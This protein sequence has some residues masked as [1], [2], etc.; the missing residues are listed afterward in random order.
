MNVKQIY[1]EPFEDHCQLSN[2]PLFVIFTF[3]TDLECSPSA[4]EYV[5]PQN[6]PIQSHIF[7]ENDDLTSINNT[8][9][10][11][12][13]LMVD[14][15]GAKIPLLSP[16]TSY[17]YIYLRLGLITRDSRVPI[18]L[19]L[20]KVMLFP[21]SRPLS[22][23]LYLTVNMLNGS[24]TVTGSWYPTNTEKLDFIHEESDE[25][26]S[27]S[28]KSTEDSLNS[29]ENH[30]ITFYTPPSDTRILTEKTPLR[31][32]FNSYQTVN[33]PVDPP[34]IEV[35]CWIHFKIL[36]QET[37][38]YLFNKIQELCSSYHVSASEKSI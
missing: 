8:H 2:Q 17:K 11:Y 21:D 15:S 27:I 22:E 10:Q 20:R 34:K 13:I 6:D 1:V 28:L 23:S 38:Q 36:A 16:L 3:D 12:P 30:L 4:S 19:F 26:I 35:G 32:E 25:K 18:T 29:R 14:R 5:I 33:E 7:I 31:F 9:C 24:L 37:Y